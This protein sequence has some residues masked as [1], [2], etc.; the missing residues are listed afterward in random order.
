SEFVEV[1]GPR[2][3]YVQLT[4]NDGVVDDHLALGRGTLDVAATFD[5][6]GRAGYDGLIGIELHDPTDRMDSLRYLRSI[7]LT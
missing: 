6:L 4:D 3:A 5:V 1:L 7:G 2:I